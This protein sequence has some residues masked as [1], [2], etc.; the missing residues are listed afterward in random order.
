M[1]RFY[2]IASIVLV[3]V[4]MGS[5]IAFASG[6]GGYSRTKPL[7]VS[8]GKLGNDSEFDNQRPFAQYLM[9]KVKEYSNG[10]ITFDYYPNGQLGGEP[11]MLDQ[12]ISGDLDIA[13]LSEGTFSAVTPEVSLS[14]LPFLFDSSE[15]FMAVAG[16]DSGT[17]YQKTLVKAVDKYGLFKFIGPANGLFRALA[18]RKH[19]IKSLN[20]FKNITLR[21]QPGVIYSDSYAA[22][23]ASTASIAFGELYAALQQGA[24]DGEDLSLPFFYN[25]KF[26]EVEK[27]STEVRLFFQTINCIVSNDCWN[28][29]FTEEDRAIFMK[30]AAE[31][32]KLGMEDQAKMDAKVLGMIKQTGVKVT[33]Y[34]DIPKAEVEK[35]RKVVTPVWEKHSKSGKVVWD[36]LQNSLTAYRNKR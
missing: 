26:Y 20:D 10:M 35:M 11:N 7:K 18:N 36:A 13:T 15:E 3:L 17:E 12:V 4:I 16:L 21:V 25:Y 6:S 33:P 1:R 2:R 22:L 23:G 34:S 31:A 24:V 19:E 9:E 27:Y 28:K 29:K 32:Q 14:L 8:F 30:A 5:Q